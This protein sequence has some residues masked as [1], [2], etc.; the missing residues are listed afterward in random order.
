MLA[1]V[2]RGILGITGSSCSGAGYAAATPARNLG[3]RTSD[4][5]GSGA[6]ARNLKRAH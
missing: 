2:T 1:S 5:P 3:L 4:L 6:E